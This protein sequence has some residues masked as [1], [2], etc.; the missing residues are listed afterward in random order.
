MYYKTRSYDLVFTPTN[1]LPK[2][3]QQPR[4]RSEV[5]EDI[6]GDAETFKEFQKL[7]PEAREALI[8]FCMGNRGIKI[9]YDPFF[10]KILN[11]DTHPER[12]ESLIC[13]ILGQKISI[14][15][16]LPREGIQ[17]SEGSSLMVVDVLVELEDGSL[18][19]VEIQRHGL[20]FPVQRSY[21]YGS[22]ILVR[23]Y[24]QLRDI[25]G[26]EFSYQM[27]HPV[28]VIVLMENS[29][30][31]FHEFPNIYLHR[32]Q[33]SF[34]SGLQLEN[35]LNFI[36]IPLDIFRDIP[37]N[38][39]GEL[40]AWLYFLGSDNPTHI[41]RLL[42]EYPSFATLYREIIDF[43]FHPKELI[44]MYSEALAIMDR[45]TINLM[46]DD[47]KKE[48]DALKKE[49]D[50][51]KKESDALKKGATTLQDEINILEASKNA[52]IAERDEALVEKNNAL[53]EKNNALAERD[54][55]LAEIERLKALLNHQT[56]E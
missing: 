9:T 20:Y 53:A 55:A 17:L 56:Q 49:S 42:K 18:V 36:Y 4:L 54:N 6:C 32:S 44:T 27:M 51:L 16:I 37:H 5:M 22:D 2:S 12:L 40:E 48:V 45:N 15:R 39:I 43:R 25:H 34:D 31:T 7:S 8:E 46:I 33:S 19:N 38:K 14:K 47:M 1:H 3:L 11:P 29:P 52:A 50:A 13:A 21:C 26:H 24:A 28:Y 23:Q 41:Q 35:L 30:K 10:R